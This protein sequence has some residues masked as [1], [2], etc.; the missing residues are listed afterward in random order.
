MITHRGPYFRPRDLMLATRIADATPWA[1]VAY[2]LSDKQAL[3]AKMR[4]NRA[5]DLFLGVAAYSIQANIRTSYK[6]VGDVEIDELYVGAN[7]RGYKCVIPVQARGR[8]QCVDP[9]KTPPQVE[10]CARKFP[11]LSCHPVAA[12]SISDQRFALFDLAVG[13]SG[14][15]IVEERHY[16]LLPEEE[17]WKG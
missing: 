5:L 17:M 2:A 14:V 12:Q 16:E 11:T 8:R 9:R 15:K 13:D 10:F 6:N 1:V 4:W 7:R 3:L